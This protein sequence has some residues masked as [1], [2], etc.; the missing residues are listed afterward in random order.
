MT[1]NNNYIRYLD[2]GQQRHQHSDGQHRE[3]GRSHAG[4]PESASPGRTRTAAGIDEAMSFARGF[5][6]SAARRPTPWSGA[7]APSRPPYPFAAA[8]AGHRGDFPGGRRG[9]GAG[10]GAVGLGHGRASAARLVCFGRVNGDEQIA[11]PTVGPAAA[12]DPAACVTS[13]C[14]GGGGCRRRN[15]VNSIRS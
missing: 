1:D 7:V 12:T 6:R 2:Y 11:V 15:D 5:E 4:R 13:T 10:G 3:R 8:G 14:G 9:P